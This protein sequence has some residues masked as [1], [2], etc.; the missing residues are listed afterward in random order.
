M[1]LFS[2][3]LLTE[4]VP[5]FLGFTNLEMEKRPMH[6]A[7]LNFDKFHCPS[8]LRFSV[9]LILLAGGLPLIAFAQQRVQKTFS[10]AE[11]ASQ[12]YAAAAGKND[13]EALLEILGPDGKDIVSS[14]DE[15]QDSEGR[16]TFARKYQQM[17]RLVT[18]PNGTVT[19]YIG[20]ENWPTPIP[21]IHKG[22][23]WF[24]DT[25]AGIM[26]IVQRRIG[27]NEISAIRVCQELVVAQ[28]EFYAAQQN[29]YAQKIM[30]DEGQHNG[31]YWKSDE[32]QPKSPIGPLLAAAFIDTS[33]KSQEPT[34]YRGYYFHLLSRPEKAGTDGFTVVAYPADYRSSGVMSFIVAEDGVV[35]E[36]DLGKK[37]DEICKSMKESKLGSKWK[38]AE[39]EPEQSA[40]A[41]QKN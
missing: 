27:E 16:T 13:E 11:E 1:P 37:T 31:L 3:T 21:I 20:A 23:L 2:V 32:G 6:R 15:A 26:E 39:A 17:H 10:S 29:K 4:I 36:R 30:S 38:T 9:V 33:A 40:S 22:N 7:N 8:I 14:G 19:L 25:E 35:Y 41:D 24:F 28:K 18:E 34:P 5:A 12:A